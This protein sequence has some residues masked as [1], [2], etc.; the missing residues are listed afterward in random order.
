M[1][2]ALGALILIALVYA[3]AKAASGNRYSEMTE[4]EFEAEAQRSSQINI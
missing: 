2:Y 1:A 3:I 4:E